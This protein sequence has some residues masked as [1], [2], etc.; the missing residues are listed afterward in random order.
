MPFE[1]LELAL[2]L[3]LPLIHKVRSYPD[4]SRGELTKFVLVRYN[5]SMPSLA[6]TGNNITENVQLEPRL[7]FRFC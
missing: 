2:K 4:F 6:V 3:T 5:Q 7:L 1:L